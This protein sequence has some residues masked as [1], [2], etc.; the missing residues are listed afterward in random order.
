VILFL[1]SLALLIAS[2]PCLA[3]AKQPHSARLPA[4]FSIGLVGDD[5]HILNEED[6]IA[7]TCA[8]YPEPF[9]PKNFSPFAYW[10]CFSTRDVTVECDT[11]QTEPPA[12]RTE[13]FLV[14]V[15]KGKKGW[16]E[17]LARHSMDTTDC[18][19]FQST[20]RKLTRHQRHVCISGPFGDFKP[21]AIEA[22]GEYW[23]FDKYKTPL[24]CDS[25]VGECDVKKTI[26][27]ECK[28]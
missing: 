21:G 1:T 26:R 27:E 10:Q 8:R 13:A 16:Q 3:S 6:L 25:F 20:W 9:P 19:E 4:K 2:P 18:R 22:P 24:G 7:N 5:F 15:A 28:N 11:D 12:S 23:I 17:Y 14:V